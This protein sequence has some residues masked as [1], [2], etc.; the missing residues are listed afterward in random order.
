M[1]NIFVSSTFKDLEAHRRAAI[2]ALQQ[3]NNLPLTMELFG[4]KAG[5]AQTVSLQ[6]V[7]KADLF[8]GIY[9]HRYGYRPDDDKSVTEMEY[10]EA[11]TREIDRLVFMVAD[12]Y[13]DDLIDTYAEADEESRMLL[14]IFKRRLQ[15]ENVLATFTTPDDLAHKVLIALINWMQ[16]NQTKYAATPPPSGGSVNANTIDRSNVFGNVSGSTLNF[17]SPPGQ[18]DD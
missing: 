1:V 11:K 2:T 4:S 14:G 15:K 5:D 8:I 13:H 3:T 17:G 10:L 7:G 16:D 9:A 6:E 18:D 12:D